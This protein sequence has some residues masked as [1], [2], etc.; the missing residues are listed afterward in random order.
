MRTY[1]G[2]YIEYLE[3]SIEDGRIKGKRNRENELFRR[4]G[5]RC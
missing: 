3:K 1:R 2:S 4:R 5:E